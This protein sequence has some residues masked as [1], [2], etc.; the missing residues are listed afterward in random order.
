V[1]CLSKSIRQKRK[2]GDTLPLAIAF[3]ELTQS[4]KRIGIGDLADLEKPRLRSTT[5]ELQTLLNQP[6]DD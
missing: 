4:R 1:I 2:P 6:Q 3:A 5:D